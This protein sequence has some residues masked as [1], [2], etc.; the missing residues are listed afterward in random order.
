VQEPMDKNRDEATNA[1][2]DNSS[3]QSR[4][5]HFSSTR[6]L[7]SLV[8]L[9]IASPLFAHPGY[10]EA[11]GGLFLTFVALS[12]VLTVRARRRSLVIAI[13]LMAP[14]LGGSWLNLAHPHLVPRSIT[15]SFAMLY[16]A[17]VMLQLLGYVIGARHVTNDVLSAAV[18]VYLML[19]IF[20]AFTY[21]V[22]DQLMP[23]SFTLSESSG[24]MPPVEGFNAFCFSFEM[25]TTA[26]YG[27]I[28]PKS[29][30]AR[31]LAGAESISGVFYTAIMISRLVSRYGER[32]ATGRASE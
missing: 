11:V 30:L 17:Y 31:M 7:I 12:A 29:N 27:D 9:L 21:T 24:L 2:A 22:A 10:G 8:L 32:E 26:S 23:G 25:L 3:A 18:C 5:S 28:A 13:A 4:W 16:I 20:W 15:A 1:A 19:G 14:A 6:L